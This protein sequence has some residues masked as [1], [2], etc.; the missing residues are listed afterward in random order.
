[1]RYQLGADFQQMIFPLSQR[2]RLALDKEVKR[3][4]S[5]F[6]E[7]VAGAEVK[8]NWGPS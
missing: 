3:G 5:Q 2:D 7:E 4:P 6:V 1:M 8:V